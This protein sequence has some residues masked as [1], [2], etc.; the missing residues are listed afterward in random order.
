M[1]SALVTLVSSAD[2][3]PALLVMLPSAVVT[4][5]CRLVMSDELDVMVPSADVTLVVS[6]VIAVALVL[7]SPSAVVMSD[8]KVVMSDD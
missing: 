3:A 5:D 6:P 1:P 2:I 7:I 4:S 8:C